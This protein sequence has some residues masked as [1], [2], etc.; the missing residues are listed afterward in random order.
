MA[1]FGPSRPTTPEAEPGEPHE[2]TVLELEQ[3]LRDLEFKFLGKETPVPNSSPFTPLSSLEKR[4]HQFRLNLESQVGHPV[5]A[6]LPP[7]PLPV[8]DGSDLELF[9][10]EFERWLRLSGVQSCPESYQLDWL[11]QCATP[12]LK[13]IVERVV[14][15]Q[16]KLESVL[17]ALSQL[18]PKLENDLTLRES[19]EKL[20]PLPAS[21]DPSQVKRLLVEFEEVTAKMSPGALGEQEKYLLLSRKVSP[22]M[23]QELRQD[24]HYKRR[25]ESYDELKAC[26]LEKA[27]EDWFER[28]L[29]KKVS[30]AVHTLQ[31]TP[32]ASPQVAPTASQGD[33]DMSVQASSSKPSQGRGKGK[34][35]GGFSRGKG[36][37]SLSF[38]KG[39]GKGKGFS[40]QPSPPHFSVTVFCK[41]CH[42]KGHYEDQCWTKQ[43][44]ERKAKSSGNTPSAS[45]SL[46]VAPV[47]GKK[48]K[49]DTIHVLR[50]TSLTTEVSVNGKTLQAIID[51]GATTSAI[52]KRCVPEGAI[53]RS[54]VVPIQVGNGD[55]IFSEGTASLLLKF[56]ET[57]FSQQAL[58]VPTDAF[59][60]VLG[61]DF[62]SNPK[63][64]GLLT[65][66]PPCKLLVDGKCYPLQESQGSQIH[67]I[68]RLFKRESY[69]LVPSVREEVLSKLEVDP[70]LI[71]VDLFANHA[72]FQESKYCTRSNSAY[73]YDWSSLCEP[74]CVLWA[75][76]PFS[77]LHRVLTKVALEPQR[78]VLVTPD[79]GDC[80]WRRL[81]EKLAVHQVQVPE[82]LSLYTSDHQKKA[83]PSPSWNTLV[84]FLDSSLV[85]IPMEELDPKEVK[86]VR[87]TSKGW[88]LSQ[89]DMEVR[90]YPKQ[91]LGEPM[92]REVQTSQVCVEEEDFVSPPV[93]PIGPS[94]SI[95]AFGAELFLEVDVDF[96]IKDF[97][98]PKAV[99]NTEDI[100]F[101]TVSDGVVDNQGFPSSPFGVSEKDLLLLAE[102][103]LQQ[104][105]IP[106]K[107]GLTPFHKETENLQGDLE[108]DL[109]RFESNPE[110]KTLLQKYVDIFGQL[111][112]PGM[113]CQLVQCD[114]ELKEEFKGRVIRGKCW[115]MSDADASEIQKQVQELVEVGLV[116][117]YPKGRTPTFCSPTFLVEKKE[118][119]TKRMVGQYKK[120]N[121]MTKSHS[122]FLPNME[123][124]VESL[125]GCRFKSKLDLR[126]GFWQ[127]GMSERAKDITSFVT[128]NGQVWR[129]N[130]MPFGIQSAPCVFQDLME[131]IIA[132]VKENREIAKL[133]EPRDGQKQ[134]FIG[135]FFDDVGIGSSTIKE[136][137]FI[138]EQFFKV[139]QKHKLRIKLS[140]CDLVKEKLEYLGF[141][142]GWGSWRPSEKKIQAIVDFKVK[143]LKD[144]RTFLGA[145]NFFRRHVKAFTFSSAGLTDL[146]KKNAR[147]VWTEKEE[148]LIE[149]IKSKL[150]S[151]VPLGVPRSTGEMVVVTDASDRG[152]GGTLFQWQALDP[153]QV[154]QGFST[155]GMSKDGEILHNYP[156]EFRLVPLGHWNWKWCPTRSRYSTFE[157]ELLSGV[158]IFSTQ[159]R[160][161]NNLP[162]VW[163]C[164]HEALK[165]FLD[166]EPPVNQRLRRWFCFLGQ[167]KIKFVH[168]PGL[169]NEWCDWLSRSSFNQKFDLEFESLAQDAFEKM[170][171]QLDL[172]L[173]VLSMELKD[174]DVPLEYGSSE[175]V[176]VWND[177]EAW[178]AQVI[179]N[180]LW[181]K[182]KDKL[183]C[184]KKLAIPKDSLPQVALWIHRSHG[185]PGPERT[186]WSFLQ[187]FHSSL[188]RK[189][190]IALFKNVLGSCQTCILSKPSTQNDRGLLGCLPIPPLCNDI[191]YLDFVALDEFNN[192]DYALGIVDGLSRFCLYLPCHKE[193]TGEKVL[194]MIMKEWVEKF[195]RPNEVLSDN[196]V[197]FK[198]SI[199]FYQ[200]AMKML[201]IKVSFSLPRH[202]SSNGLMERENRSFV[203]TLRCLVQETGTKDWPK[204]LPYINFVLNSQISSV[205]G[206]S[207]SELFH[208]RL[209]WK[210]QSVSE[211]CDNPSVESWLM[212]QLFL[213]EKACLRLKHLR[214]LALQRKNRVRKPATYK[215]GEF[216]LVHKSRWPQRKVEK[217]ASPWFG[218]FKIVQVHFNSLQVLASPTLGGLVKVSFSQ[219]KHWSSV[220]DPFSFGVND[221]SECAGEDEESEGAPVSLQ[222]SGFISDLTE[223]NE[224]P[225]AQRGQGGA[226]DAQGQGEEDGGARGGEGEREPGPQTRARARRAASSARDEDQNDTKTQ[227]GPGG[228]KGNVPPSLSPSLV[229]LDRSC[230][231]RGSQGVFQGPEGPMPVLA[232]PGQEDQEVEVQELQAGE[233]Q[234]LQHDAAAAVPVFSDLYVPV[235]SGKVQ[236]Y[237]V[238][239]AARL[240]FYNV[241]AILAHRY[242]SGWHFLV[243]WQHF[244]LHSASWEPVKSF[245]LPGGKINSIFQKY[246]EEHGL[247]ELVRKA[248]QERQKKTQP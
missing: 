95:G 101:S 57:L 216:V 2:S 211:P 72:N 66:P 14:E 194:R 116:E 231:A 102:S 197:R 206:M 236:K 86:W 69:S 219:V 61:M 84:S 178:K 13:R 177:L 118:S 51:S 193:I 146:L 235:G 17:L 175:Y 97:K 64:G 88:D 12:K 165:H 196:D 222:P 150:L 168:T 58:V 124:M 221:H 111:P 144:L 75:N 185:H 153:S 169:K 223:Q 176:S 224:N 225:N 22:K 67:R 104:L 121:E 209:P 213:Q 77:Q 73:F 161:I 203:Q 167:F 217:I 172:S 91:V 204:L 207:P 139:V 78:I 145:C 205:T 33:V 182:T 93:S 100:P 190:L 226:G 81:L 240:G 89:L 54:S 136:H 234:E 243:K 94:P 162:V 105:P 159:S 63:V 46:P 142:V 228:P 229:A 47:D 6:K 16:P 141:C 157:Q 192:F 42:K 117:A 156:S 189:E 92:E 26:L 242:K 80:Y 68:Y 25:T 48:R 59:Q 202:P 166:K 20:S 180:G 110:L 171:S 98:P 164:D 60:A 135:A 29:Q 43:K 188:T 170:D 99:V 38:S 220:H 244:P 160:I 50:G 109:A 238:D 212:E 199:G 115:P 32:Q 130:C 4:I 183:F 187:N 24:R 119:R 186:L 70:L 1:E 90:K 65:Q 133:L 184:E 15:E 7:V 21:P 210:F 200:E 208:G 158:L 41:F 154:P 179:E 232:D 138:L 195:G 31:E 247:T 5:S 85:S 19:L 149:E 74:K 134:C 131:R 163:F 11:I 191:I 246:A 241:E 40:G 215:I 129:W 27:Q 132:E 56:G 137:L 36:N 122:G 83:L 62:L 34:G 113:G 37:P 28:H 143:N 103:L 248:Q 151:S 245:L 148:S 120:V 233:V 71:K 107:E 181:F 218:P 35:K 9:L 126:S 39:K 76:P 112:S 230:K 152:G 44:E 23:F 155:Q 87:K 239:E 128:P 79:W 201:G 45:P 125:A 8:F 173:Q 10:K 52:A 114:L 140:K 108:T 198:S 3:K 227:V 49:L 55:T 214:S 30:Q 147:F 96:T 53:T 106:E 127:V 237:T 123:G 82:G 18:F 174:F